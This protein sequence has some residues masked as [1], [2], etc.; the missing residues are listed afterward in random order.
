MGITIIGLGPGDYN[1]ITL[2]AQEVLNHSS[3]VWVRT[4]HHP[5]V[6]SLLGA[7]DIHS[8]DAWYE[9]KP[10]FAEVYEAVA[11]EVVRLGQRPQGV[12]YAVPGHP[13]VGEASVLRVLQLAREKGMGVRIVPGLS[14]VEPVCTLLGVDPLENGLQ[15]LDAM[16]LEPRSAFDPVPPFDPLRPLLISQLYSRRVASMVKLSLADFYLDD[17]LVVLVSKAG[18]T[19]QESVRRVCLYELDRQDDIGHLTSLYVPPLEAVKGLRTF[20]AIAHIVARLRAPGGCPWDREQSHQ[21]LKRN[22]LQESYEVLEALDT[23]DMVKLE[24][25][26]GDLLMQVV[27]HAQI[28]AEEGDFTIADVIQG[29]SKKLIRRHPHVFADLEVKDSSEVLRNWERIKKGERENNGL[30]EKGDSLLS[31]IP[32]QLPALAYSQDMQ[33]RVARV[34]FDW[35]DVEGVLG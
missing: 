11:T 25:E 12:V 15:V 34:G 10:S 4:A 21:T 7:L 6:G 8:F 1:L 2:E 20:S 19:G 27:L 22:L 24:E 23:G 9:Q 17:H 3:E 18:V 16:T 26:L 33:A 31:S 30:E 13:L 14:F 32:K 28:A 29:I 35:K 5:T